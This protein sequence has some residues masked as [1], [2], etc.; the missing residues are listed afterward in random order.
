MNGKAWDALSP[1][2][3]AKLKAAAKVA[4]DETRKLSDESDA[5]LV[6]EFKAAGVTINEIDPVPFQEAAAPVAEKISSV[7]TPEFMGRVQEIL[8]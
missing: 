2:M 7:V 1:E 8:K 5:K 6:D 4:G 3:Q